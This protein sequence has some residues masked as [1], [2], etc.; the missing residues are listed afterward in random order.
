M[1]PAPAAAR[2]G[3][4]PAPFARCLA[5]CYTTT[6]SVLALRE[7]PQPP[8]GSSPPGSPVRVTDGCFRDF[9]PSFDPAGGFLAFLS[10]RALQPVDDGITSAMHFGAGSD[11]PL[12]VSLR[13]GSTIAQEQDGGQS[14]PRMASTIPVRAGAAAGG[15]GRAEDGGPEGAG[16]GLELAEARGLLGCARERRSAGVA[17]GAGPGQVAPAGPLAPPEAVPVAAGR[18]LRLASVERGLL[19]LR[20]ASG[21]GEGHGASLFL[22]S[23]GRERTVAS[24]VADFEVSLD[25]RN[26]L[27]RHASARV[28]VLS[29]EEARSGGAAEA[30]AG[31]EEGEEDDE[32][33][34]DPEGDETPEDRGLV[35]IGARI[36][37]EV[38]PLEEWAQMFHEAWRLLRDRFFDGG[39]CGSDWAAVRGRYAALLGRLACRD[40]LT[41]LLLEMAGELGVARV[42]HL[43][44]LAP[45]RPE[46][47]AMGLLGA[48]VEWDAAV[49]GYSV[50]RLVVGDPWDCGSGGALCGAAPGVAEGA[51]L[52][53]VN[54]QRLTEARGLEQLLGDRENHEVFVTLVDAEN[55]D[56]VAAHL[57]QGASQGEASGAGKDSQPAPSKNSK[58]KEKKKAKKQAS[59]VQSLVRTVRVRCSGYEAERR[60]RYRDWVES[61]RRAV[62]AA[63]GGRV[64]YL[65][66]PDCGPAGLAEFHRHFVVECLCEA[67]VV[68]L[69]GNPGGDALEELMDSL[70]RV[71]L[72]VIVP[73]RGRGQVA[74]YPSCCMR[75]KQTTVLLVDGASGGEAEILAAAFKSLGRGSLVGTRTMGGVAASGDVQVPLLDGSS[76]SLPTE[77]LWS[78]S[79]RGREV[80][81]WGVLPDVEAEGGQAAARHLRR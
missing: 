7:A 69:R 37:L 64:G 63:S 45:Y 73:R 59:G 66:L 26:V 55:A 36:N 44:P 22:F 21:A 81:N 19:Y 78:L 51:R 16:R 80:E 14:K 25:L 33:D 20:E 43:P 52:L 4:A 11:Q 35:A 77:R 8:P 54:R 79:E 2:Q 67:V 18:Y 40:D 65:H 58:K 71:P 53:A 70:L 39:M 15:G 74:T 41:D 75:N 50:S 3:G 1:R 34:P 12:I 27:V 46:S 31:E 68:D 24:G 5:A 49:A 42:H 48:E 30:D 72:G 32:E 62:S 10:R 76:L 23:G 60:A 57:R 9:S 28:R 13:Q 47:C 6:G 17:R 61:N 38:Q 56:R 29:L